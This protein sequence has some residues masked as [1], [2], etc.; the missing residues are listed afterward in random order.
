[1]NMNVV[2]SLRSR[3]FI[4][5]RYLKNYCFFFSDALKRF[6]INSILKY[7]EEYHLHPDLEPLVTAIILK[8]P[9]FKCMAVI[10]DEIY[11]DVFGSHFFDRIKHAT[12]FKILVAETED[13]L[14]PNYNTLST[15]R[16]IRRNSCQTYVI[17][18]SN[19]EQVKRFLRFGDKY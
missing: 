17:L 3:L 4:I 7:H 13:L 8:A 16:K 14:S 9:N 15:I 19:G 1:M 2:F 5:F 12:F 18:L 11:Q 6:R 10:C